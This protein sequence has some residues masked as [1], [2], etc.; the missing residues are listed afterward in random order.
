MSNTLFENSRFIEILN[1]N[2]I[3]DNYLKYIVT[4]ITPY[5]ICDHHF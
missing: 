5:L 4:P 1:N 2:N 3:I